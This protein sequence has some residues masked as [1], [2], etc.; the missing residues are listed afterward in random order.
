M[1]QTTYLQMVNEPG[2]PFRQHLNET[3]AALN[4]DF[5]GD[6]EP[7]TTVAYMT[8]LDTSLNPPLLKRRNSTNDAWDL[9][10]EGKL[11]ANTGATLIGIG[12]GRTKRYRMTGTAFRIPPSDRKFQGWPS[13]RAR[14]ER[15]PRRFAGAWGIRS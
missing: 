1:S 7:T 11:A 9:E 4:T 12:G 2:L 13:V 14:Q 3:L 15:K 5:Q 6:T 8:W 10:I